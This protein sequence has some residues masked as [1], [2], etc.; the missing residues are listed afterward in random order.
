MA[1]NIS[2]TFA[3]LFIINLFR[4]YIF[5]FFFFFGI[6]IMMV[7]TISIIQIKLTS[8][9]YVIF[10]GGFWF[11]LSVFIMYPP[12]H[13][14][15]TQMNSIWSIR[16]HNSHMKREAYVVVDFVLFFILI[17]CNSIRFSFEW[18]FPYTFTQGWWGGCQSNGKL[19]E[20]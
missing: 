18:F 10:S 1:S 16:S 4:R 19:D 14:I 17:N 5:L 20:K 6:I 7:S 3:K 13:S 8:F 2:I 12:M 15:H 11:R 9:K